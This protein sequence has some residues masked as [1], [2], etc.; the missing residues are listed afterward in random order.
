MQIIRTL[1][2][3]QVVIPAAVRD[4]FGIEPGSLLELMVADDHIELR[5]APADPIAAFCG[6]LAGGESLTG[7]LMKEHKAEVKR[8]AKR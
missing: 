5:P 3:G 7:G 4:R 6:S 1:A 8:D 2:K